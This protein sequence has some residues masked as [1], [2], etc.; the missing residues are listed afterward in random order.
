MANKLADALEV[1]LDYLVGNSD[2]ELDK[3]LIDKVLDIQKLNDSDKSHVF[4]LM[5]AFLKQTKL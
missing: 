3:N 1:S 2:I 5:D 4:A